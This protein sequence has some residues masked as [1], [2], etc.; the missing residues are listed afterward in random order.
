[1]CV[2]KNTMGIVFLSSKS[3]KYIIEYHNDCQIMEN[4]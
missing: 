4:L 2:D 1:M 3:K